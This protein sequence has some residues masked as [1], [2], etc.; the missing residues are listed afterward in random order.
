[1]KIFIRKKLTKVFFRCILR[2]NK[3]FGG[4]FMN[5]AKLIDFVANEVNLT[6][7]DARVAIEAVIA[8]INAG[9]AEDGK[10]AL[11]G[12]GTFL[13][14]EKKARTARNPKTGEAVEVPAKVVPKFRPSATLKE[15]F[16]DADLDTEEAELE[17]VIEA[18]TPA[19]IIP[20]EPKAE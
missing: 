10:V 14:V 8:G 20:D 18:V 17:D 1:M 3:N 4:C 11:V 5:K 6:K 19:E 16:E 7:R 13:L 12:F 2:T 15:Y 9:L